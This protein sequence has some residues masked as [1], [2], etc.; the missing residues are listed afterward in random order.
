MNIVLCGMM[1]VGKT[2][3]GIRIAELANM[4]WH[5]TDAII[6]DKY[7]KISDIFE[8]YGEA[9]FRRLE[10]EVVKEL[11]EEDNLVIS[12]GGGCVLKK[13][14]C[15]YL[16]KNGKIVFLKANLDTLSARVR[17]ND[18]RPLLKK[19]ALEKIRELLIRRTPIYEKVADIIIDTDDKDIDHVAKEI[20]LK[21]EALREAEEEEAK[22]KQN[23][24]ADKEARKVATLEEKK[25]MFEVYKDLRKAAK[26]EKTSEK[27]K[28]SEDSE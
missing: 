20:I 12:T 23:I 7:G 16:K 26:D 28:T 8:F 9:H 11:A 3:V 2:T 4:R 13:E 1:G 18:S 22:K 27:P 5:D 10:T 25:Y 19:N 17:I 15:T 24:E 14:N 6:I 21:I